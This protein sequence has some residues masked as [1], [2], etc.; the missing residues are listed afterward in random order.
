MAVAQ[1]PIDACET[2][3]KNNIYNNKMCIILA[4]SINKKRK[5]YLKSVERRS[6]AE[7]FESFL[8]GKHAQIT[9]GVQYSFLFSFDKYDKSYNT[10]ILNGCDYTLR[11]NCL[12][13]HNAFSL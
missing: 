1:K 2:L 7:N 11:I 6:T 10:T 12:P 3:P 13:V 4:S 8:D 9:C 5:S